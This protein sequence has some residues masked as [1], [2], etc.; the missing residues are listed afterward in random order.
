MG[1][2]VRHT[3]D[4]FY[5][6]SCSD[7]EF[8]D[9]LLLGGGTDINPSIYGERDHGYCQTPN[10]YR[11]ARNL[12]S[13][14]RYTSIGKPIIGICRGFQLLDAV[15]GGKLIQHTVGHPRGVLVHVF[16]DYP[17]IIR[18]YP[19]IESRTKDIDSCNNCHH[20]VVNHSHTKGKIIGWS[21]YKYMAYMGD[22][23]PEQRNMVPEIIYWPEK[24]HFAVQ[25]HPEWQGPGH[26]MNIYLRGLIKEL[27]GLENVL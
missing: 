20:Q 5:G 10:T 25:F 18:N 17:N 26:Q 22:S 8:D 21:I 23:P 7:V 13:I 11:D 9:Y 4:I 16:K 27:L 14:E 12:A 19:N 3:P 1:G 15:N 24:K 2:I 6:S